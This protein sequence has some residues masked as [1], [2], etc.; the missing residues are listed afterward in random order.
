[1]Q[2]CVV[3]SREYLIFVRE[4]WTRWLGF[5]SAADVWNYYESD[6][7]L[8][9]LSLSQVMIIIHTIITMR[10]AKT[11]MMNTNNMDS[12]KSCS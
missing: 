9:R 11:T 5:I 3:C 1:M 8:P 10:R 2:G 7:A 4:R 6:A 12:F